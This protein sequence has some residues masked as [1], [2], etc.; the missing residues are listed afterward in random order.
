MARPKK[1]TPEEIIER[2]KLSDAKYRSKNKDKA[3]INAKKWA[4]HNPDR[5]KQY[6]LKAVKKY[7]KKRLQSDPLFKLKHNI[8]VAVRHSLKNYTKSSKTSAILGCTFDEFK[9]HIESQFKPWMTWDNYGCKVPS[10]PDVT[11]DLDHIIPVSS[12]INEDDIK[13]L[14]HYTNFQPLCSFQNRFI[15]RDNVV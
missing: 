8:S 14:N 15:K 2:R 6:Q 4:E 3:K 12:A 11:W 7:Q 5:A 13:R 9:Q 10:G 1:Y